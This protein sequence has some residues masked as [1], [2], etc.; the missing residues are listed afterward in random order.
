MTDN[1]HA[2][3]DFFVATWQTAV[4]R[5]RKLDWSECRRFR[6]PYWTTASEQ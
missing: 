4:G 5:V 6:R 1:V 2:R 3:S